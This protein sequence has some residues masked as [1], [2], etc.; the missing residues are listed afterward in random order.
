MDITNFDEY[1]IYDGAHPIA[2]EGRK[3]QEEAEKEGK[4]VSLLTFKDAVQKKYAFPNGI[5]VSVIK[6]DMIS[7]GQWEVYIIPAS[8]E[9]D[10]SKLPFELGSIDR[11]ETLEE[12]AKVLFKIKNV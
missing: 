11:F 1:K 6:D 5:E 9:G 3:A 7:F 4:D 12:V 2:E 10:E 8:F